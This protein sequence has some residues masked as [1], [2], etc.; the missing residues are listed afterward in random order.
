MVLEVVDAI[1]GAA[2]KDVQLKISVKSMPYKDMPDSL[3]FSISDEAMDKMVAK[4]DTSLL[5]N[6]YMSNKPHKFYTLDAKNIIHVSVEK[7]GYEKAS[8]LV[9]TN[10]D[11]MV[12]SVHIEKGNIK[13]I[14]NNRFVTLKLAIA[15]LSG[16]MVAEKVKKDTT[17][18]KSSLH[19]EFTKAKKRQNKEL[20]DVDDAT[21]ATKGS[22]QVHVVEFPLTIH[23]QFN[24]VDIVEADQPILD[25]L[26][27]ILKTDPRIK[28]DFTTHTDWFG[29]DEYNMKLSYKRATFIKNYIA[30]KGISLK[31]I[32]GHGLGE[33][34]HVAPNA[35]PDGSDNPEGRQL[36]RRTNIK[37]ITSS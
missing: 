11:G 15:P 17:R 31:R 27:E 37:L 9:R 4:T 34:I 10:S 29:S 14:G 30:L 2:L 16:Q 18:S 8:T 23:F 33:T 26:V 3:L 21:M 7:R 28:I 19:K 22:S 5:E 12:D 35:Y 20:P 13:K 36:N 32:S 24:T 6:L 25:S 1:S